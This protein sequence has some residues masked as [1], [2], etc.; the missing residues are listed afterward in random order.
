VGPLM[1]GMSNSAS[2]CADSHFPWVPLCRVDGGERKG[3]VCVPP[4]NAVGVRIFPL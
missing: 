3:T 4:T 1:L 2:E